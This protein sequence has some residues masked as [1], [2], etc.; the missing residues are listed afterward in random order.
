MPSIP[1][2][3]EYAPFYGNYIDKVGTLPVLDLLRSQLPKSLSLFRNLKT[4]D[5]DRRYAPGKWTVSEVILHII[6]TEV[7]ML[8][9][10]LY[11]AR[12]DPNPLPNMDQDLFVKNGHAGSI[13]P[14]YLI[15]AYEAVRHTTLALARLITPD[16]YL[17]MGQASKYKF[18][19]RALFYIIAG[20]EQHHLEILKDKYLSK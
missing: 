10:A 4:K 13:D 15:D 20:H 19:V 18:S 9:R 3:A 6:D 8:V 1:T 17:L 2:T 7:V 12:Q 16:Q 14:E 5:F 11:I